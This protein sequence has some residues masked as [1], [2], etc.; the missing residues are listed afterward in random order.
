MTPTLAVLHKMRRPANHAG[1]EFNSI[2]TVG[3]IL[4]LTIS[5]GHWNSWE[6]L[7]RDLPLMLH[8]P[9]TDT[10]TSA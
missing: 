6:L 2:L 10:K 8:K 5:L 4:R 3:I 1:D 9:H 7:Q